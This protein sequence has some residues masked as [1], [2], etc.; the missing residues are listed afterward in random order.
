MIP[1]FRGRP[2]FFY[3]PGQNTAQTVTLSATNS[4]HLENHLPDG[5]AVG[6]VDAAKVHRLSSLFGSVSRG[7]P[8]HSKNS[9]R[10]Q[11]VMVSKI[12]RMHQERPTH[13]RFESYSI[14]ISR[15]PWGVGIFGAG[16]RTRTATLSP[17]V[18]FEPTTST[19][20]SH[21]HRCFDSIIHYPEN[22]KQNFSVFPFFQK[23]HP[24]RGLV[25]PN[26]PQYNDAIKK[27]EHK[28]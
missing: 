2:E 14:K 16:G 12:G 7:Q 24:P 6:K 19:I 18:D 17:A 28:L 20:P 26:S 1:V 23:K 11:A 5:A 13:L 27:K 9:R 15:P 10:R 25:C 8:Y 4:Q 22:S 3:K 21:R